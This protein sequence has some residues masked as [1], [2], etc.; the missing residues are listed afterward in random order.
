M[1]NDSLLLPLLCSRLL[2][3]VAASAFSFPPHA[4]P[5]VSCAKQRWLAEAKA[6]NWRFMAG[7][8]VFHILLSWSTRGIRQKWY[9]MVDKLFPEKK[10]K[11]PVRFSKIFFTFYLCQNVGKSYLL[12]LFPFP[13]ANCVGHPSL[14]LL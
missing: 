4:M 3:R 12:S 14:P 9:I 6:R 7:F 1:E 13:S 2:A 8:S 10:I 11:K 5:V